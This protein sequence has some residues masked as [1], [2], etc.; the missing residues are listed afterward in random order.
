MI[1]G[2]TT[3]DYELGT[4][5]GG[6]LKVPSDFGVAISALLPQ[7]GGYATFPAAITDGGTFEIQNVPAGSD[8]FLHLNALYDETTSR[9]PDL[10][11]LKPGRPDAV[12]LDPSTPDPVFVGL[13]NFLPLDYN[14]LFEV[15]AFNSGVVNFEIE[16]FLTTEDGGTVQPGDTAM[17]GTIDWAS[18]NEEGGGPATVD[19][20]LGDTLFVGQLVVTDA[21]DNGASYNQVLARFGD[22]TGTV[23]NGNGNSAM[24]GSMVAV[25]PTTPLSIVLP[26]TVAT[27]SDLVS[28]AQFSQ[29]FVDISLLP[30]AG[31]Y[32]FW[33]GTVDLAYCAS[34]A[35][36][37]L[38]FVVN[39]SYGNP[40]PI[41]WTPFA[42]LSMAY[43]LPLVVDPGAGGTRNVGL[44]YVTEVS[45]QNLPSAYTPSPGPVRNIL[46]NGQSTNADL[47]GVGTTPTI[48]WTAPSQ[49]TVTAY[50]VELWS[51]VYDATTTPPLTVARPM[52]ALLKPTTTSFTV[53]SGILNSSHKWYIT[54]QAYSEPNTDLSQTPFLTSLPLSY[55]TN[56]TH[57]I[58]P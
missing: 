39:T 50:Q 54:V 11:V 41:D 36:G 24:N 22:L 30:S 4:Y 43:N 29:V 28:G 9:T 8:Y 21:G 44:G 47:T 45:M 1:Q 58:S 51:L 33:D 10:S 49:G 52:R 16:N 42:Y 55:S 37:P 18:F 23:I 38:P 53:P 7:A 19:P 26:R 32:G 20:S 13:V 6:E 12:Q 57:F 48:S 5:D 17:L 27:S 15:A 14:Q 3:Y 31:T 56:A 34:T 46:V 35:A 25:N 40:Y 2:T